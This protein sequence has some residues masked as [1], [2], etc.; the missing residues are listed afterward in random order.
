MLQSVKRDRKQH[1]IL[2]KFPK[3]KQDIRADLPTIGIDTLKDC[4]NA[5]MCVWFLPNN[6]FTPQ[7]PKRDHRGI[8]LGFL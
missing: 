7:S 2:I 1:G 8:C 5:G 4:N 3:K 6:F